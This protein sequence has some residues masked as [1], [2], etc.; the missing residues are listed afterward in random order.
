M[1]NITK[2]DVF[3]TV[4]WTLALAIAMLL[5]LE[6]AVAAPRP[7]SKNQ[8]WQSECGTPRGVPGILSARL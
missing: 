6:Q 4:V 3:D 5:T 7:D 2:R 8:R 1:R